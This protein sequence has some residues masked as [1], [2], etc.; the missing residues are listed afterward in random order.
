ME[1]NFHRCCL[2]SLSATQ[3]PWRFTRRSLRMCVCVCMCMCVRHS[4][5]GVCLISNFYRD[6][7]SDCF[8]FPLFFAHGGLFG[9]ASVMWCRCVAP[10]FVPCSICSARIVSMCVRHNLIGHFFFVIFFSGHSIK[11]QPAKLRALQQW[12]TH[13]IQ[14][15]LDGVQ[16]NGAEHSV[17]EMWFLKL[18]YF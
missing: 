4:S 9:R 2:Q 1:F 5:A 12:I 8:C 3:T 10:S 13:C 11:Q 7:N 18:N 17:H 6:P 16:H 15:Q 14:K